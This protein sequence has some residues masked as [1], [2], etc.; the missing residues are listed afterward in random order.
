MLLF[1]SRVGYRFACAAGKAAGEN[2]DF[3]LRP[4]LRSGFRASSSDHPAFRRPHNSSRGT[5]KRF[6]ISGNGNVSPLKVSHVERLSIRAAETFS[7]KPRAAL[8]STEFRVG[9]PGSLSAS[10]AVIVMKSITTLRQ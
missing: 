7:G 4:L 9:C 2:V 6:A 5:P 1:L 3:W 10:A 8:R